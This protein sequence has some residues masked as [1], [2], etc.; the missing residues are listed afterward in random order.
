M[1]GRKV[2]TTVY[3]TPEQDSHLKQV[4]LRTRLAVAELVRRERS[5]VRQATVV[6]SPL[7]DRQVDDAVE[8]I[9]LDEPT[10]ALKW[11]DNLLCA[12]RRAPVSPIPD[13]PSGAAV[14]SPGVRHNPA[15]YSCSA[16]RLHALSHRHSPI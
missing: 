15:L 3:L 14:D 7:A 2:A 11:L 13:V 16:R 12:S 6:W 10:A 4:H 9:A 5:I 8:H 1:G